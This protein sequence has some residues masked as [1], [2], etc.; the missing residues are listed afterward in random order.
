MLLELPPDLSTPDLHDSTREIELAADWLE[1]SVLFS[2]EPVTKPEVGD[3]LKDKSIFTD[4]TAASQFVDDVWTRLR[5]R[6]HQQGGRGPFDFGYQDLHLCVQ[7]WEEA[8]AQAFCLILS[9]LPARPKKTQAGT[10]RKPQSFVEQGELFERL[11]E[12][13]CAELWPSWRIH[14]T[15]WSKSTTQ[16]LKTVVEEVA[17]VLCGNVGHLGRWN[18]KGAK[19]QGLDL[20]WYRPFDDQHGAFP[21]FLIQCASGKHFKQK[22]HKPK[23]GIWDDLV[24]VI[25]RSL[26]RKAFAVPFSFGRSEFERHAIEG[27]C[28]LLDR[29]RLLSAVQ[30]QPT[31]VHADLS[32]ALVKWVRPRLKKLKWR[33]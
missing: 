4:S 2:G 33:E 26:P 24:E 20:I 1:G 16:G 19:E 5:S 3:L 23:E 28:L 21:A 9:V 29:M 22:L 25:P 7:S 15:G 14:R 6:R 10:I 8:P 18:S 13:A 12:A 11:V 27:K 30:L 32:N 31:W 17:R